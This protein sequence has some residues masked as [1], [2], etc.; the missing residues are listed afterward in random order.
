MVLSIIKEKQ[1][2]MDAAIFTCSSNIEHF[3]LQEIQLRRHG[4]SFN[5]RTR[6]VGKKEW[7]TRFLSV[8]WF[9]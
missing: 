1:N 3:R 5:C 4:K 7:S 6:A 9:L 2:L 8:F